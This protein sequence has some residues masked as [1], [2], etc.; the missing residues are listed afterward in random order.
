MSWNR[1]VISYRIG[2]RRTQRGS[3]GTEK[4]KLGGAHDLSFL[5]GVL[6]FSM[7]F[8]QKLGTVAAPEHKLPNRS[9]NN[10][11]SG[12]VLGNAVTE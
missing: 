5:A 1:T 12:Q 3:A 7:N 4:T 2:H 10:T 11:T 8:F 9:E 6:G